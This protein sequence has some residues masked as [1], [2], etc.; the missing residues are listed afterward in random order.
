MATA[1]ELQP[2]AAERLADGP[3]DRRRALER[4]LALPDMPICSSGVISFQSALWPEKLE[5]VSAAEKFGSRAPP[6]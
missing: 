1:G 3:A 6:M 2:L 5:S 4:G